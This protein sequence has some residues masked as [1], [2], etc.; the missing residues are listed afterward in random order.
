MTIT[1][2]SSNLPRERTAGWW[3]KLI[4]ALLVALSA[5]GFLL[6]SAINH[7]VG[8]PLDDSWIHQTYARNLAQYGQWA[9]IPGVASGGSTSPLWSV[10]LAIGYWV[11]LGPYAWTYLLG[12]LS[13]WG[14]A[15]LAETSVRK[16]LPAYSPRFP[17]V[18]ATI[19]LEWHLVWASDSGMETLLQALLVMAVLAMLIQGSHRYL[20][21]GLLVGVSVWVRPDGI[22]LL[23]PAAFVILLTRQ[24]WSGRLKGLGSLA[25]GFACPF[26]LYLFFNLRIAGTPWPNTFYAKQAEYAIYLSA[27]I[28]LRYARE[29]LQPLTGA[30]LILLPGLILALVS[31]L[32]KKEWGVLAAVIWI[33]GFLGLYAWRL[34]VTY[35][36][37]RYVMPVMPIYFLLGLIGLCDF[38]LGRGEGWRWMVKEFWRLLVGVVLACF[39]FLGAYSYSKDVAFIENEMVTTA[40]WVSENVPAGA[41]V[42]AHDIGAMGYFG[43]HDLVD[44]AGLITPQVIPFIRD[45]AKISSYLDERNV[46]YLVVFPDWYPELT[47]GRQPIFI[48]QTVYAPDSGGSNM[49]VYRWPGP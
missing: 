32:R 10:L 14:L 9:F 21:L 17:W 38:V 49:A 48:T 5:G 33:L 3:D 34:P 43:H 2:S 7:H 46:N 30:G 40:R 15:V 26:A 24:A 8:F 41:L 47:A 39:W 28:L 11:R 44:L 16:I 6:A 37:G 25:L 27:P 35:Q 13:L 31:S 18:G 22:T 12:A 23:G 45:E 36:Y 4:L 29:A 42:A 19:A 1:S 20:I